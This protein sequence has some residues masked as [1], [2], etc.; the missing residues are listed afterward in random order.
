[1]TWSYDASV[2]EDKDRVRLMIGDTDSAE[3]LLQDEEI[4][5]ILTVH[6]SSGTGQ[7]YLAAAH[8]ADMIAA[9]FARRADRSIGKLSIQAK[10]QRDHYV[11]LAQSLRV[12]HA[13]G[14]LGVVDGAVR[15]AVPILGGGG[16]TTL[17]NV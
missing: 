12:G 1:M 8:A 14:G 6:P 15:P 9:Q 16:P 2:D 7:P 13:T 3:G 17:W 11:E 4:E 5:Y 10:Q